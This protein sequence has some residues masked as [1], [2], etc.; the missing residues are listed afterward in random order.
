MEFY[1]QPPSAQAPAAL[2]SAPAQTK[3]AAASGT[4]Q[5]SSRIL[6]PAS[7]T[8]PIRVAGSNLSLRPPTKAL[9]V[10]YMDRAQGPM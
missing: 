4:A 8:L 7:E 5:A 6:P 2:E 3:T 1:Q 9:V 10:E